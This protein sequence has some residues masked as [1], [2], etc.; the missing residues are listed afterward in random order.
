MTRPGARASLVT[1]RADTVT[2]SDT[3]PCNGATHRWSATSGSGDSTRFVCERC[4][5]SWLPPRLEPGRQRVPIEPEELSQLTSTLEAITEE[6][7]RARALEETR[8]RSEVMAEAQRFGPPSPRTNTADGPPRARTPPPFEAC[9]NCLVSD[10]KRFELGPYGSL[11]DPCVVCGHSP[12]ARILWGMPAGPP[13][14]GDDGYVI[15]GGCELFGDDPTHRCAQ[16]GAEYWEDGRVR[17]SDSD[18]VTDAKEWLDKP[19]VTSDFYRESGFV[20]RGLR[21]MGLI[22][23]FGEEWAAA[24]YLP[25]EDETLAKEADLLSRETAEHQPDAHGER[26][27]DPWLVDPYGG[28]GGAT[29]NLLFEHQ[30]GWPDTSDREI[31]YGPSADEP[32]VLWFVPGA[33][34]KMLVA[35]TDALWTAATW[36]ELRE[37]LGALGADTFAAVMGWFDDEAT[38]DGE[39]FTAEQFPGFADGDF[40]PHVGLLVAEWAPEA[41]I[42]RW[43]VR[44]ETTFNG[45]FIAFKAADEADVVA[46]LTAAGFRCRRDDTIIGSLVEG[47]T[48]IGDYDAGTP[49][50]ANGDEAAQAPAG[51]NEAEP[52]TPATPGPGARPTSG[53]RSEDPLAWDED[54]ALA[55][56]AELLEAEARA[57]GRAEPRRSAPGEDTETGELVR[58]A[59]ALARSASGLADRGEYDAAE[60]VYG[61]LLDLCRTADAPWSAAQTLADTAELFVAMGRR[62][63]AARLAGDAA[64]LFLALDE[65]VWALDAL[66]P[67]ADV[68]S[69]SGGLDSAEAMYRHMRDI[70]AS[71]GDRRWVSTLDMELGIVAERR[72][73]LDDARGLYRQALTG[74]PADA[75]VDRARCLMNLA[76]TLRALGEPADASD[77]LTE[78]RGRFADAGMRREVADCDVNLGNVLWGLGRIADAVALNQAGRATYQALGLPTEAA[79]CTDHLGALATTEGDPAAALAQHQD[80]SAVYLEHGYDLEEATCAYNWAHALLHLGRPEEALA[81]L[82]RVRPV[83]TA[84]GA[85]GSLAEHLL[86]EASVRAALGQHATAGQLV[87]DAR[88]IIEE[89]VH[90]G[91]DLIVDCDVTLG[92]VLRRAGRA[93]AAIAV[94]EDAAVRADRYCGP[95]TAAEAAEQLARA[96]HVAGRAGDA[97]RAADDARRRFNDLGLDHRAAQV[98][99][100]WA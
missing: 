72:G 46:A 94:L 81:Q 2:M 85:D 54:A 9:D 5:Q 21:S 90:G 69:D 11:A 26:T 86:L 76:A 36:G 75:D 28:P 27:G 74:F 89:V 51:A 84:A 18:D 82:Q 45:T 48:G 56:E 91:P 42:G 96:Y 40:P 87:D 10:S 55:R 100:D 25:T 13:E 8:R 22:E 7:A 63:Q 92:E 49:E 43:G 80:A 1:R 70:A 52:A 62:E 58:R 24:Q 97:E 34:G 98:T 44:M 73:R 38:E 79:D 6:A 20:D 99:H 17:P 3:P 83:L 59:N 64:E 57:D 23:A 66:K 78:A 35:V 30:A 77:A 16:C 37:R 65:P 50:P 39:S 12:V 71:S 61:Q 41:V 67:L 88:R 68:L 4:A 60:A 29:A 31:V 33:A 53:I 93:D 32:D 95:L 47:T 19:P 14:G 15:L